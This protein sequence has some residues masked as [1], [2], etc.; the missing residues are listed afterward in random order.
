MV[1]PLID[2]TGSHHART[3]IPKMDKANKIETFVRSIFFGPSEHLRKN[4]GK[5]DLIGFFNFCLDGD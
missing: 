4:N 1:A 5:T 2:L 3:T